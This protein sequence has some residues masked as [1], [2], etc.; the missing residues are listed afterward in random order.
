M[1][2][3]PGTPEGDAYSQGYADGKAKMVVEVKARLAEKEHPADCGHEECKLIQEVLD[4]G[5]KTPYQTW[6]A[7]IE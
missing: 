3:E 1:T 2:Y 4:L 5:G 6:S 7:V